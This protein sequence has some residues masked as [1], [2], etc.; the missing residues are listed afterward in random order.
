[1]EPSTENPALNFRTLLP[2]LAI[3]IGWIILSA[4]LC[5]RFS[6]G[7]YE[8]RRAVIWM[9]RLSF[10]SLLDLLAIAKVIFYV[11][12]IQRA[13]EE[14]P[15]SAIK[16]KFS[17]IRTSYW[18]AIKIVCILICGTILVKG[19]HLSGGI[20]PVGLVTGISTLVVVPLVGGLAWY[21]T[22]VSDDSID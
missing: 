14:G 11:F 13:T 18:G 8:S 4:I 5:L 20:P 6:G 16:R 22:R 17:I 9:F 15:S 19:S 7:E 3:A 2:F 21:F 12:E 1:M 10:I